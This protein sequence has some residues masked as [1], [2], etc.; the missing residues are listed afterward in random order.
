MRIGEIAARSGVTTK[1]IRYYESIGLLDEPERTA[2]GYRDYTADAVERL[3]FIRDAQAS[4]L[5]LTEITSVLEL[6]A[7]GASSCEHTR[8]LLERHLADLDDQIARLQAT[9]SQLEV[10]MARAVDLDPTDCTDTLRC[11][12]I[13]AAHDHHH[14]HHA[15]ET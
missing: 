13:A 14:E 7:A 2:S 12:V 4:G 11:Q 5:M 8:Q 9:R 6:K 10:L 15:D 3:A 1:T